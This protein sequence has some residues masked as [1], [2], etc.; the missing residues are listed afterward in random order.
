MRRARGSWARRATLL[1]LAMAMACT[2][3]PG[4]I[5]DGGAIDAA[6]QP[7][8]S[9]PLALPMPEPPPAA[10]LAVGVRSSELWLARGGRLALEVAVG[11]RADLRAPVLVSL[12]GLPPGVHCE[13][14]VVPRGGGHTSLLLTADDDAPEVSTSVALRASAAG[15]DRTLGLRL[16]V[17][18]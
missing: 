18:D 2:P 7:D 1:G 14:S 11:T 8:A 4:S 6:E 13:S 17:H 3:E 10:P 5:D 16:V 15:W 9:E 12:H